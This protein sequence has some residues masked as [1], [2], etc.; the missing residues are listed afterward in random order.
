VAKSQKNILKILMSSPKFPTAFTVNDIRNLPKDQRLA[1]AEIFSSPPQRTNKKR[2][3]V[4]K[5]AP[6]PNISTN[7][8]KAH[9]KEKY[10][11]SKKAHK[12][13]KYHKSEKA[14]KSGKTIEPKAKTLK[15]IMN[16]D[17]RHIKAG[18]RDRAPSR[19]SSSKTSSRKLFETTSNTFT[20][21]VDF[22]TSGTNNVLTNLSGL[23]LI[24][25]PGPEIPNT[26]TYSDTTTVANMGVPEYSMNTTLNFL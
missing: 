8:K 11:K 13:E 23:F 5:T 3:F 21:P 15:R 26:P 6:K 16:H 22:S 20:E 1:I 7:P 18:N 9:K 25:L 14:H 12:K 17:S 2:T 10:H 4:V 24:N 19:K